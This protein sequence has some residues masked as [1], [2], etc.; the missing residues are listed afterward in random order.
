MKNLWFVEY[1]FKEN[2][3]VVLSL[4]GLLSMNKESYEVNEQHDYMVVGVSECEEEAHSLA[5]RLAIN[6]ASKTMYR[7]IYGNIIVQG[8]KSL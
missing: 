8:E 5:C 3:V 4:S 1:S 2:Q 7:D 6:A